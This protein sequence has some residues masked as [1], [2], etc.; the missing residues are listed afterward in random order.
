MATVDLRSEQVVDVDG[1]EVLD[2]GEQVYEYDADEV[3]VSDDEETE[4]LIRPPDTFEIL[5]ITN[6]FAGDGTAVADVV[7]K[8]EDIP[9][10]QTYEVRITKVG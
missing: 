8:I 2:D 6:R 4:E 7:A 5:S 9:G 1:L 3:A 10:A